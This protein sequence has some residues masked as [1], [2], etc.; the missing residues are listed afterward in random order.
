MNEMK[1]VSEISLKYALKYV[2]KLEEKLGK[3]YE[4]ARGFR[5]CL[6]FLS[7]VEENPPSERQ[8][9]GEDVD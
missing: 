8:L 3:D 5:D 4:Y 2:E 6:E 7:L 1:L 9:Q